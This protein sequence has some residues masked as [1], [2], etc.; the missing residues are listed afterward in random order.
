MIRVGQIDLITT[1][2]AFQLQRPVPIL[3]LYC[4]PRGMFG[5]M[6][7]QENNKFVIR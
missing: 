2:G 5:F 3:T 7:A 6:T 1:R 4:P